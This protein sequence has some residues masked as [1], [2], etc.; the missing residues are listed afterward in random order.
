M[1]SSYLP[2]VGKVCVHVIQYVTV[3]VRGCIFL[4]GLYQQVEAERGPHQEWTS[5][6]TELHR[7]TQHHHQIYIYIQIACKAMCR[8]L[9][10]EGG[11]FVVS[12]LHKKMYIMKSTEA[13][14]T[15]A[16]DTSKHSKRLVKQC[17]V[18]CPMTAPVCLAMLSLHCCTPPNFLA[19]R[20]GR[21]LCSTIWYD[22]KLGV[23]RCGIKP[24]Y[25]YCLPGMLTA[26]AWEKDPHVS[27]ERTNWN[28]VSGLL[29]EW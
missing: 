4:T 11:H 17:V 18:F 19:S 29:K 8:I 23:F 1:S 7:S 27:T 25:P 21:E 14:N 5:T 20:L 24:N 16:K 22:L 15:I 28:I 2:R 26:N 9:S 10:I 3:C 12:S 6:S 13:Y